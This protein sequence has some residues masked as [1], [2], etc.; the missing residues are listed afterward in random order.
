MTE[1]I[2]SAEQPGE[3]PQNACCA[4]QD[5]GYPELFYQALF[6][7]CA[8]FNAIAESE[9]RGHQNRLLFYALI[10]VV[11]VSAMAPVV[12]LMNTGGNAEDLV[13][14]IP[15][16][17]LV[18]VG[19]WGF[20]GLAISLFSFAFTGKSNVKPFLILSGL[21]TLPW[22]LMAPVSLLKVGLGGVG[23][24]LSILGALLIW[25]WSVLLF[26]LALMVTYRM[27]IER[28]L[29]VLAAPF[30]ALLI[31]LGWI[32]GFTDNIR[33]LAPHL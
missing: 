14:A 24:A 19:V 22:V 3:D 10:S 11:I 33:Q 15:L 27:T 21:A 4:S 12:A 5:A 26:A 16:G 28:V 18:G 29:I 25:L 9:V 23:M 2:I 7:P 31:L 6:H 32:V 13:L 17:T 30:V 20:M 1:A 8:T